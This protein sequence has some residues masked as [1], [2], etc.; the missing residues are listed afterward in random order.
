MVSE[1]KRKMCDEDMVKYSK[2]KNSIQL[3][4]KSVLPLARHIFIH[5]H[6]K[7]HLQSGSQGV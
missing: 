3:R 2:Q 6:I 1:W 4:W 5:F 7:V